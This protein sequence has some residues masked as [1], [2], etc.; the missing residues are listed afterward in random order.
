MITM[1]KNKL[2][3][4]FQKFSGQRNKLN[5]EQDFKVLDQLF[6]SRLPLT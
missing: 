1:L 4:V 3:G 2:E 5:A 6:L